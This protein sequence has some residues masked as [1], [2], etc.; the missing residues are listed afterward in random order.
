MST[1]LGNIQSKLSMSNIDNIDNAQYKGNI[2]LEEF[3]VG[4]FLGR[5]DVEKVTLNIDVDGKGFTQKNLNTAFSG[6]IYKLRYN[7]QEITFTVQNPVIQ[8]GGSK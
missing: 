4:A 3:N 7:G 1:A 5:K 2:I 6:D 8:L